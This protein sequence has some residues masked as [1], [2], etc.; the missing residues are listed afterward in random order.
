MIGWIEAKGKQKLP[1]QKIQMTIFAMFFLGDI[2]KMQMK[3][4]CRMWQKDIKNNY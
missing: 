3:S 2:R 1:I 4:H